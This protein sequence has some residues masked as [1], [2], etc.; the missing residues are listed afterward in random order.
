MTSVESVE[1]VGSAGSA[2]SAESAGSVESAESVGWL[3]AISG[4]LPVPPLSA[5]L[6]PPLRDLN[7]SPYIYIYIYISY[8]FPIPADQVAMACDAH[9]TL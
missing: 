6:Y 9:A 8:F 2:G 7:P 3:I 1:S 5:G 4:P